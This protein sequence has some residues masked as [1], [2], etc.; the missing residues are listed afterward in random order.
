MSVLLSVGGDTSSCAFQE[1]LVPEGDSARLQRHSKCSLCH[2][3]EHSCLSLAVKLWIVYYVCL[4][5]KAPFGMH[6]LMSLQASLL[7]VDE[8]HIDT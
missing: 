7:Q 1:E 4:S 3:L 2:G 8:N 6:P 5:L